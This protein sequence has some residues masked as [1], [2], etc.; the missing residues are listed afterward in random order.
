MMVVFIFSHYESQS[1]VYTTFMRCNADGKRGPSELDN[2]GHTDSHTHLILSPG[3]IGVSVFHPR[4]FLCDLW[5]WDQAANLTAEKLLT[6]TT[7]T[8]VSSPQLH[9]RECHLSIYFFFSKESKNPHK[10][11]KKNSQLLLTSR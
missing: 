8:P 10:K 7:E 2:P 4:T 1:S 11:R 5:C 3:G 6:L 9:Q